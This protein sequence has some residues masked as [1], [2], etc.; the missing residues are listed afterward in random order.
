M[1][2]KKK[3][4]SKSKSNLSNLNLNHL[5]NHIVHILNEG[6]IHFEFYNPTMLSSLELAVYY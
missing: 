1:Q 4:I 6:W 2:L 3:K 5:S